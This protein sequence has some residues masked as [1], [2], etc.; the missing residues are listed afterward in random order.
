MQERAV[1]DIR[2]GG[3]VMSETA[4]VKYVR[5]DD[6][7]WAFVIAFGQDLQG[8]LKGAAARREH[9]AFDRGY[10]TAD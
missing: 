4:K 7:G 5:M 8:K 1:G 3:E 2:Q 6:I 9:S 10:F